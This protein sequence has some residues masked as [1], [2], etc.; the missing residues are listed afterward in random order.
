MKRLIVICIV[1]LVSY[2]EILAQTPGYQGKRLYANVGI[3]TMPALY[4][5]N[6]NRKSGLISFNNKKSIGI[7]YVINRHRAVV[8]NYQFANSSMRMDRAFSYQNHSYTPDLLADIKLNCFSLGYKMFNSSMVAPLGGY[9]MPEIGLIKYK[10]NYD[11]VLFEKQ[12]KYE[13]PSIHPYPKLDNKK[14]Y[15]D[16][17]LGFSFGSHMIFVDRIILD[18]GVQ[19]TLTSGVFYLL[20]YYIIESGYVNK[21]DEHDYLKKLSKT[22]LSTFF[23]LNAHAGIGILIF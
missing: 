3:F 11:T 17:S 1:L 12:M 7:E 19:F 22:R 9:F 18:C 5:P 15:S 21:N 13:E 4:N 2:S 20:D 14:S 6:A 8:F 10:I 16:V 23:L